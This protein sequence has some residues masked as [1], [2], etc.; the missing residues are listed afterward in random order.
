MRRRKRAEEPVQQ[1]RATVD[2]NVVS[3]LH[4]WETFFYCQRSPVLRSQLLMALMCGTVLE[5]DRVPVK[6]LMDAV[7]LAFTARLYCSAEIVDDWARL[8]ERT[9]EVWDARD[10]DRRTAVFDQTHLSTGFYI[11]YG[12][13]DQ[14]C[15]YEDRYIPDMVG[16]YLLQDPPT[17]FDRELETEDEVKRWRRKKER[18]ARKI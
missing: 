13:T 16:A 3:N 1:Q 5:V 6:A 8:L 14:F 7:L 11:L 4:H 18:A 9:L 15:C 10:P 17:Y 2:T 12:K